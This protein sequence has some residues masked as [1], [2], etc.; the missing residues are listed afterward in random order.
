MSCLAYSQTGVFA[1]W[2]NRQADGDNSIAVQTDGDV[3]T[4]VRSGA[5]VGVGGQAFSSKHSAR[6]IGRDTKRVE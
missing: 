6:T 4:M 5:V 2:T 3:V 1:K